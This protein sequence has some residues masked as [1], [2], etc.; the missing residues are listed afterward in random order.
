MF[1]QK[2]VVRVRRSP[3]FR[4]RLGVGVLTVVVSLLAEVVAMVV[5]LVVAVVLL[6]QICPDEPSNILVLSAF[7]ACHA[8]QRVCVNDDA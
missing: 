6:T 8:P 5:V 4:G 7:E 2:Q 1:E 3:R